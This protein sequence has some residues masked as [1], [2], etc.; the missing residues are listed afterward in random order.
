[1]TGPEDYSYELVD[2]NGLS[3]TNVYRFGTA[4]AA[5]EV[6]DRASANYTAARSGSR[7]REWLD[8]ML[9]EEPYEVQG[10]KVRVKN[11]IPVMLDP[12]K[13]LTLRQAAIMLQ[14]EHSGEER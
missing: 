6:A 2:G 1:M 4:E 7:I 5:G 3:S 8:D 10:E 13:D 9:V 11:G 14:A 12:E